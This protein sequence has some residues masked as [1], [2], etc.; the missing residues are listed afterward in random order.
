MVQ[1]YVWTSLDPLLAI[2]ATPRYVDNT[3][4]SLQHCLS[5][6]FEPWPLFPPL[7]RAAQ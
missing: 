7:R 4:C 1:I 3:V 5:V 2:L 6:L